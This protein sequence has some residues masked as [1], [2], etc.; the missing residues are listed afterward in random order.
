LAV[1]LWGLV[2]L[3]WPEEARPVQVGGLDEGDHQ[4]DRPSQ[5]NGP[6]RADL[7]V[8]C[9]SRTREEGR[10]ND[11]AIPQFHGEVDRRA[12]ANQVGNIRQWFLTIV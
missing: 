9:G 4:N 12:L 7:V 8:E 6:F 2:Q 5:E 11:L 1:V 3:A 10:Q